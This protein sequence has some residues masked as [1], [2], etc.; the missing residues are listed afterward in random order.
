VESDDK[1]AGGYYVRK[2]DIH[3]LEQLNEEYR[4]KPLKESFPQYDPESQF[5]IADSRLRQLSE[6][7]DL[8]EKKV[9]EVGCGRGYL[10]KS[11][12]D[13]Y[14][15]SVVGIDISEHV[16]WQNLK[17]P[18]NLDYLV[19]DL[20]ERNPFAEESF[21]LIVS[22][23]AWEHMMHPFT[24]LK[25]CCRILKPRGKMYISANLYRSPKAS[26][27][28]RDIYFP[29][30]HLLFPEEVIAEFC[31]KNGV[32]KHWFDEY[33]YRNKLTYGQY[34]EYFELLNLGIEYEQFR[35]TKLD[36]DFYERF[37]DK[38]EKYP[39]SDLELDFFQVLL[40]KD[41]EGLREVDYLKATLA[42][43][44]DARRKE[45]EESRAEL[46]TTK[47]ELNTTKAALAKEKRT[48]Q[49]VRASLSFQLGNMLILAI[50]KPGRNTVLLP[51]RVLRLGI[52]A[53]RKKASPST[54]GAVGKKAYVLETVKERIN[55]I[56]QETGGTNIYTVE[57]RRKDLGIAVI[58]DKFT[59][60]CFK[61]EA[62]LITFAPRNWRK[63]LSK[64]SPHF[65]LVESAWQGNDASWGSQIVNLGQK[66]DS[67][68][69]ELV[70]WCKTQ[71]IPTAFWNKEDPAHY[72]EF[73]D[74]ARLFDYVFTT[75]ADCIERYK[76]DLEHNNVFCL[77]FAVQ[78]RIHN[79]IGSGQKIRD[80]AFAGSWHKGG[81]EYKKHRKEQI[82]NILV[83]A[84]KYGVDIYDRNYS[85]N[86]DRYRFPERYQPYI[87]GGLP[88]DEMVYAYKMY[89]T[90]LNVN[91]VVDSPTMFPRRVLEILASGTCV[92]SGYSKGIEN[93]IGSDIVKMSSSPQETRSLLKELLEDNELRDRLAHQGLRKVMREHTY[94]K[95]LDYILNTVGI[96]KGNS[97]AK[98]RGVSIIT[99][100]NKLVYMD[101]IFA[102]YDRQEYEDKELIIILNNDRLNLG[103]WREKAKS[104]P[105]ATVYQIDEKEPLGVCL[106]HGIEKARFDYIS[107][108][109]DDNY[110]GLAFLEDL[111]NAFEYTDAAIVGKNAGYMYFERGD[112]LALNGED[113]EHCYTRYVLGSAI[114]IKREVFD[115]VPW[116]TDR[117]QGSDSEFLRQS[118][119]NGFKIYSA[120]RFNYVCVRRSSPELHTWKIKD[121]EQ[122]AKCRIV[123]YTKDYIT[124]VTC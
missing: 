47:V 58:M 48:V 27:L 44:R 107:K 110:Y 77:P 117:R 95:R 64:N 60:D 115:R 2:Y 88:Y 37:K 113:K 85:M 96:A 116:P 20:S 122:I 62:N 75:D 40:V 101:N 1:N 92:L 82:T 66:S 6:I 86:D 53:V 51:Y 26:H 93:L 106:N 69:P 78:P 46:N 8:K 33:Y 13:R 79:P 59:Y 11:L 80:V 87:V 109:D 104:Y 99:S 43:E 112:I 103:E 83:P 120:D 39:R 97:G 89:R 17:N 10:S 98:E 29:F 30:P 31:L 119:E 5:K 21:D 36:T 23:V 94:D 12:A 90:F 35:K 63:V 111:M 55:E 24:M 38:L 91:S 124:H 72:E 100:T 50:R 71:N 45:V 118:V 15:C 105:N 61:Y 123:D 22:F 4:S 102:N 74:A 81:T 65:L 114:I 18:P 84:L 16:E 25:E 121:E 3:L 54:P 108:F 76:K 32:A 67:R 57:P 52:R 49:V 56:R 70:Q 34:K 14:G 41:Y 68:L 73:L 9:L 19:L 7:V 42:R 28:Y